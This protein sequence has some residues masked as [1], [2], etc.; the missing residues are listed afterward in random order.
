MTTPVEKADIFDIDL[1]QGDAAK[2]AADAKQCISTLRKR[3]TGKSLSV[4]ISPGSTRYKQTAWAQIRKY[5]SEWFGF[6]TKALPADIVLT[7]RDD[8]AYFEDEQRVLIIHGDLTCTRKYK[9]NDGAR[10]ICQPVGPFKLARALLALMDQEVRRF[11]KQS[12]RP[13]AILTDVAT[14]TPLGTPEER[15]VVD[16]IIQTDYGFTS[17]ATRAT[18]TPVTQPS[19][20]SSAVAEGKT[21]MS[22]T[23]GTRITVDE[24]SAADGISRMTLQTPA[25][26]PASANFVTPPSSIFANLRLPKAKIKAKA[27]DPLPSSLRILAVDD[28]ALNLQLLHR[29]LL[30]RQSDTIVLAQNGL[31]ALEAV[32]HGDEGFDIIFMDISMRTYFLSIHFTLRHKNRGL[33][34]MSSKP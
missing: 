1:N 22:Q 2:F 16:G 18:N 9:K 27:A 21:S 15:S 8:E 5:C 3:A 17:Y 13:Q 28:N 32:S 26:I 7:D 14:Q 25:T 34:D 10:N 19:Q 29:Y 6:E 11:P 24:Q 30:K 23:E 33:S 12:R 31:E 4:Q 20:G